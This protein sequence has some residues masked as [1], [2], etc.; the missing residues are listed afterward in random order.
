[1]QSTPIVQLYHI[2]PAQLKPVR[3]N[4]PNIATVTVGPSKPK[5][6]M[7]E[8]FVVWNHRLDAGIYKHHIV[9]A[10]AITTVHCRVWITMLPAHVKAWQPSTYCGPSRTIAFDMIPASTLTTH[11]SKT[12]L[13]KHY[14]AVAAANTRT[15]ANGLRRWLCSCH[16]LATLAYPS[17]SW[18]YDYHN[19]TNM[20]NAEN[21][22]TY[23]TERSTN[24]GGK[25]CRKEFRMNYMGEWRTQTYHVISGIAETQL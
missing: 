12:R 14:I 18:A 17:R 7:I 8:Q 9:A 23:P 15:V 3:S 10:A 5:L 19:T 24:E 4:H 16:S 6:I 2:R 25:L 11:Y 21:G 13:Y 20:T 1:M 22:N